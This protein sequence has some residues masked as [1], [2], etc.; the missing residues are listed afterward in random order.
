MGK[1]NKK[2]KHI[3]TGNDFKKLKLKAGKKKP[4]VNATVTSFK[5]KSIFITEQLKA[6]STVGCIAM[7]VI[8]N[9]RL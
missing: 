7:H 2:A 3:N 8:M 9:L 1:T 6:Q 5:S 4:S